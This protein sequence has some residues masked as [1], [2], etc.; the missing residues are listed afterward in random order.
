MQGQ[1]DAQ[2]ALPV[3]DARREPLASVRGHP[4]DIV[5]SMLQKA[6][7]R[8]MDDQAVYAVTSWMSR[9]GEPTRGL[10]WPL[11]ALRMLAWPIRTCQP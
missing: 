10:G 8:G 7:R 2:Q 3:R 1:D 6:I 5:V 4:Q 11:S 9:G